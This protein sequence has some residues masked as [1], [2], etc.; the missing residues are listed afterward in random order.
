MNLLE[1]V[2]QE[3]VL[4]ICEA[5][6]RPRPRIT[7]YKYDDSGLLTVIDV[8]DSRITV[9]EG[10]DGE[11]EIMSNL[12]LDSV[13]PSDSATYVCSAENEVAVDGIVRENATLTVNGMYKIRTYIFL[14]DFLLRLLI[15]TDCI[16]LY[17][18]IVRH[19]LLICGYLLFGVVV[20][21]CSLLAHFDLLSCGSQKCTSS[22]NLLL[23]AIRC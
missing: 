13:L 14:T 3:S 15:K 10:E 2:E 12:T 19:I 22:C 20:L 5:T 1:A 8:T 4:F 6:G 9:S 23:S 7:W 17:W 11:R 16:L 21:L 18:H